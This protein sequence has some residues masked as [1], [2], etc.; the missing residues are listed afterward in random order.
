MP[1]LSYP[2]LEVLT[3]FSIKLS[4]MFKKYCSGG[5]QTISFRILTQPC[6]G[7]FLA[8]RLVP[9]LPS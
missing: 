2:S 7:L 3:L 8:P 6:L 1:P 5:M 9:S 4:N